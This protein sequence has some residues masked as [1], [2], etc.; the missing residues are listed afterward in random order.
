MID[1]NAVNTVRVGELPHAD[2]ILTDNVP[3]EIGTELYRGTVQQLA[4]LIG[5]YLGTSDSLAFNPTTVSDGG[6]LPATTSNEWMLVGKGTFHNVGG[7]SDIITTEELN[8]VTSNG[9]YWSLAVQIPINV[10]LAGIVQAIRSGYLQTT[11]SENEVYNALQLKLNTGGYSG[12]GQ[13]L[14]NLIN[15]LGD[16]T[17]ITWGYVTAVNGETRII[18]PDEDI[19]SVDGSAVTNY[20]ITLPELTEAKEISVTFNAS[21]TNLTVN[22]GGVIDYFP[23]RVKSYDTY[24]W[25]YEPIGNQWILKSY[26]SGD[27]GSQI[28]ALPNKG[29]ITDI[30]TF[31]ISDESASSAPKKVTALN[32]HNNYLKP[33]NDL[34]YAPKGSTTIHNPIYYRG[35]DIEWFGDSYTQGTG[36]TTTDKRFTSIV[37]RALGANEINHGV[38]GTTMEKRVPIDYMASP[39]MVD[40]VVNIP[41]KTDG[42][43]MLVFAFGLNDMGQTASAYNTANYKTDYQ[44]VLDNSFSKGWLPSQ[45]LIIPAYYIGSAGY[46]AY[47]TI[48]GNTAP[49]EARHLSF[50]QAAKEVSLAN[51]TMYFDIY[52]DQVKNSITLLDSDNIHPNDAGHA[53]IS[54]DILQYLGQDKSAVSNTGTFDLLPGYLANIYKGNILANSLVYD[55]GTQI[56]VGT[57]APISTIHINSIEDKTELRL[58][59]E[60]SGATD[61]DGLAIDLDEDLN[62]NIYL[63]GVKRQTI[64]NNGNIETFG[65]NITEGLG[66]GTDT[67]NTQTP[68]HLHIDGSNYLYQQFTNGDTG[69]SFGNGIIYGIG[70]NMDLNIYNFE[71]AKINLATLG[72]VRFTIDENGK[73]IFTDL[74]GSGD[75]TVLTDSTGALKRGSVQPKIYKAIINQTG[76]SAPT[77][78]IVAN[79][80]GGTPVF[81]YSS[82]GGYAV[83]LSGAFTV[84]KTVVI[85]NNGQSANTLVGAYAIN[86]N[87][88][89]ITTSASTTATASDGLLFNA[90]IS[91]EVYP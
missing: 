70:D 56:G 27:L 65:K 10:E 74:S 11:P 20:T 18:T 14:A 8:A 35:K 7:G 4:D 24:T 73:I 19:L 22:A 15:Q 44:F 33:K 71:S 59:N 9:S 16:E 66:I 80:L 42:K 3:H 83:T 36:A 52:A 58:T 63:E 48:T 29:T 81:S 47:A 89:G 87:A 43:A 54:N 51:N 40:N 82:V 46:A 68:V 72:V 86:A 90:S 12:T 39:N 55:S 78:T 77:V 6:T 64:L 53:Y 21:V 91:I 28:T 57:D 34:I 38:A 76:T 61:I 31:A 62:S 37:S 25:V 60:N 26:W 13:D 2:F 50:I 67:F 49:T 88:I 69:Q 23:P 45:I 85:I 30:D 79:T 41:T 84:G 1:P 75:A 32:L 5:S 17:S